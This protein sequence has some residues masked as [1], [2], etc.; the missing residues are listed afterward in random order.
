[1]L[2]PIRNSFWLVI[3]G[4]L[5][6]YACTPK[7]PPPVVEVAVPSPYGNLD[8]IL[9]NGKLVALTNNTPTSYFVYRGQPMG[10]EYELLDLFAH[11]LGVELE[12]KVIPDIH[13]LL[14]S[15]RSGAGDVAAANLTVTRDRKK[16][17]HFSAP[18]ITTR[19]VLVQRLPDNV[20]QLTREQLDKKLVR[21]AID[22]ANKTV[23]VQE[24][25]A[26]YRRLLNLQDEIGDS[27]HIVTVERNIETDSLMAMISNG[28][29][30][31]TVADENVARF[32]RAFY[33]NIDVRTPISFSQ[34]IAWALPPDADQLVDTINHWM[35][36]RTSK[37]QYAYLFNKYFKWT[38][39]AVSK[40]DSP[41]NLAE[42]GRIS[43]YDEVIR[44]YA[45]KIGWHWP[46]L[47]SMIY[48]ESH[49]DT[50]VESWTGAL[51]L[52]QVLPTTAEKY[53]IGATELVEVE[54]NIRV[55]TEYLGWLTE[56]W[57]EALSDSTEAEKFA[58]A[59]YNVGLGHVK[60][61]RR[62]AEK[63]G[64]DPNVWD[65]NVGLMVLNKSN[66]EY[67][68]DAVV[69]HGYCRGTEPYNYV[70]NVFRLYD[71]Y[72]NFVP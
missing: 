32:F 68:T 23:Y 62:L 25:S 71:H 13:Q 9:H 1:M 30:D 38:K 15:L 52:M 21:D 22:L 3:I 72:L 31:Y 7:A 10:Y 14:D 55:G 42:G 57:Q 63:Y 4:L 46:L 66:P 41:Y 53:G 12:I 2:N 40:A 47:A 28:S 56:F 18:H 50:A 61:A 54:A 48:H 64:M 26:H 69:L 5:G 44:K 49:F 19:Q 35:T 65:G 20:Y 36:D 70:Q 33:P 16:D 27:I 11:H 58:L 43:P 37:S 29:I 34:Q 60:D 6:V 39:S 17:F 45:E 67:Y 8:S 51:G 59:S 24:S